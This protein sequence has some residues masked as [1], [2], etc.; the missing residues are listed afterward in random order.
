MMG[1]R[2]SKLDCST[3]HH[4][5]ILTPFNY[6]VEILDWQAHGPA[7]LNSGLGFSRRFG[8]SSLSLKLP[9]RVSRCWVRH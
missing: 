4:D 3:N 2:G 9:Q 8:F 6:I 7:T 1:R 5:C